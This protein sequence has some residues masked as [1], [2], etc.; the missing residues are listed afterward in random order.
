LGNADLT[1]RLIDRA[2][3]K[4]LKYSSPLG[5]ERREL[6]V[7]DGPF[8]DRCAGNGLR[9]GVELV[10]HARKKFRLTQL[11]SEQEIDLRLQLLSQHVRVGTG[12]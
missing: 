4:R 2:I 12:N 6:F 7:D 11:L 3:E 1:L 8:R 5:F 10:H 9:P